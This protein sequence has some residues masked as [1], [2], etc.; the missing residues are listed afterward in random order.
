MVKEEGLV[1]WQGGENDLIGFTEDDIRREYLVRYAVS[2]IE[3][4]W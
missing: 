3:K 4:K 2:M 1:D